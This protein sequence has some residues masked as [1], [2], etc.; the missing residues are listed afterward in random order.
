MEKEILE[1]Y[2]KAGKI[3]KEAQEIARKELK[4]GVKLLDVAEKVEAFVKKAGGKPAFPLNLSIN[5][6]AAHYTPAFQDE[7]ILKEDDVIKVDLGVHI[8][9]YIADASFSLNPSGEWNEMIKANEKALEA[10]LNIVK[11]GIELGEIGTVIEK[12]LRNAGFNPVQNLTG[13]GLER[14]IQHA[15]PSIPNISNKDSRTL[16]EGHVYAIEPF[17]TNGRGLIHEAG[18]VE[19]FQEDEV[20]PVRNAYARKILEFVLEEYNGLPFAERWLRKE[21]KMD[22]FQH[23]VGLKE[24]LLKKC[25]KA[26]PVL[27]EE[28]GKMVSQAENCFAIHEGKTIVLV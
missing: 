14:F 18:R 10:A 28:A 3:L 9:G 23:K 26:Y 27:K 15:P 4:V 5:E 11:E 24:L 12:T 8:D 20:K 25:I 21:L 1:N 13:H 7:R 2:L 19:I 17:A 22:E 6:E 16:E